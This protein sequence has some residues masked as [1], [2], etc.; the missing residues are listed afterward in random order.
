[1][2]KLSLLAKYQSIPQRMT[3]HGAG[4]LLERCQPRGCLLVRLTMNGT[5]QL[6]ERC[7]PHD[8]HRV[9]VSIQ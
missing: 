8:C 3:T 7:R 2:S 5:G 6:L 1:M 9:L 4:Q